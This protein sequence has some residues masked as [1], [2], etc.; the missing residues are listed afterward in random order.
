MCYTISFVRPSEMFKR[1][2]KDFHGG[3]LKMQECKMLE[4][5]ARVENAGVSRIYG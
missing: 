2:I 5:I 3:G 1:L 4:Q